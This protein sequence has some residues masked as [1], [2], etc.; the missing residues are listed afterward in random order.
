VK[1]VTNDAVRRVVVKSGYDNVAGVLTPVGCL[2]CHEIFEGHG[3]NRVNNVQVCV[4]CHNPNLTSSA[5]TVDTAT[6]TLPAEL[7]AALG[8]N[9]LNYPEIPNNFKDMIHG[10]H[11]ASVRVSPLRDIRNRGTSG[12]FYYDWSEVT[13]PGNPIHCT[14]CHVGE[15]YKADL[16]T[17]VMFSTAK[18]TTGV[19]SETRTQI[20]TARNTVPNSTDLVNSPIVGACGMCHNS[21]SDRS[22]FVLNGGDVQSVRGTA[23]LTPPTLSVEIAP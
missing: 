14:K 18:V 7:I 2:E 22:H 16:A 4:I 20:N 13:Y 1:N 17:G 11:S 3:G 15:T 21:D 6:Q 9:P 23:V 5:R 12:V 8:S 19:S 10:I